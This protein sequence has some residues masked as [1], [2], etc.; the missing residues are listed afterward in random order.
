MNKSKR[1][2]TST[3]IVIIGLA[4][5]IMWIFMG[6]DFSFKFG[7]LDLVCEILT[8]GGYRHTIMTILALILI[9]I[10]SMENKWGFLGA[11][12]LGTLI[13]ALS[14]THVIYMLIA[15]PT[16]YEEQLFG[17]IAWSIIQ[18]PIVVFSAKSRKEVINTPT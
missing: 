14:M 15:S 4:T 9:P 11:L 6:L 13:F 18:I 17:P 10:C 1:I 3:L 12:L 5:S 7:P 2:N 16:G 8:L